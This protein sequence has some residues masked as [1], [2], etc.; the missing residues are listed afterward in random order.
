M[1]NKIFFKI[2]ADGNK[3]RMSDKEILILLVIIIIFVFMAIFIAYSASKNVNIKANDNTIT[4][5]ERLD[6]IKNNYS[7]KIEKNENNKISTVTIKCD[8]DVCMYSST[9]LPYGEIVK[10]K[11]K[12]YTVAD[13]TVLDAS[14]LIETNNTE[15]K[16]NFND[17]YYNM[18]LIKSII[19]VSNR[20]SIDNST[21]KSNVTLERYLK[22]Y[23]YI[24]S[25]TFK[26][27][28]EINI[29]ITLTISSTMINSIEIDYKEVDKYFNNSSF[30]ILTYKIYID[31]V[32]NNDY[33]SVREF[34]K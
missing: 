13:K 29:P 19:E 22:E 7:I 33:S 1:L 16:N 25:K 27:D 20:E 28:K 15:I 34:F 8:E 10:Y 14:K 24:Y 6:L 17:L 3:K 2:D 5:S 21:I 26:T 11:N 4:L 31:S 18:N 23:N 32:N 30:D 9:L 12:F